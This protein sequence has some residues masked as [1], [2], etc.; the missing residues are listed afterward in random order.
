MKYLVYS[1][2]LLSAMLSLCEAERCKQLDSCVGCTESEPN[3]NT[4]SCAWITC[5]SSENSTCGS[6]KEEMYESCTVTNNS[7]MCAVPESR[8]AEPEE[9]LPEDANK[10]N[11]VSPPV[12]HTGS[13]IG[14]GVLVILLQ[15]VGYFV[16]KHLRG[17]EG[18]YQTMEETPQ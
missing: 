17:P 7:S 1:A 4:S 2:A 14:G 11:E 6:I 8:S 9:I 10:S 18:E 16:L 12:F 5:G 3:M 13:F 15:T